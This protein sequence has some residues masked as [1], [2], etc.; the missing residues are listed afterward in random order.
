MI[1]TTIKR[2]AVQYITVAALS[3]MLYACSDNCANKIEDIHISS[4]GRNALKIEID[5]HTNELLDAYVKYW[6]K[7][8]EKGYSNYLVSRNSKMH[9]LIL[10]NL[11]PSSEYEFSIV[12]SNKNCSAEV[13]KLI[14]TFF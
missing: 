4:P 3:L 5:V 8:N 1:Q 2:N 10:T 6:P 9:K 11:L 14:F 13:Y 7:G 12:T